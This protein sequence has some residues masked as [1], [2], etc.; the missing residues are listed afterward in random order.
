MIWTEVAPNSEGDSVYV[1]FRK[2]FQLASLP[3]TAELRIFAD[4]CYVLWV[5]GRYVVHG[6]VRFDPKAPQFDVV[7]LGSYLQPGANSLA[8]I[9]LGRANNNAMMRH[10]PGLAAEL[11]LTDSS[12]KVALVKTEVV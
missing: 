10:A 3:R 2:T 5:N 7:N 9:V 1:A 12:G 4:L 8:V 6:P 11:R